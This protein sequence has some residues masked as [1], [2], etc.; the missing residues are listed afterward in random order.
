MLKV[1]LVFIY[2]NDLVRVPAPPT[3]LERDDVSDDTS[4]S[5]DE[6]G[7]VHR[8][9]LQPRS[10]KSSHVRME[11]TFQGVRV[12]FVL[13]ITWPANHG[14]LHLRLQRTRATWTF[15]TTTLSPQITTLSFAQRPM[16]GIGFLTSSVF[17][18]Y[19][20]DRLERATR[21]QLEWTRGSRLGSTLPLAHKVQHAHDPVATRKNS[22][23]S[24]SKCKTVA[25]KTLTDAAAVSI[26]HDHIPTRE[27]QDNKRR[28]HVVQTKRSTD[29]LKTIRTAVQKIESRYLSYDKSPAYLTKR[30]E[31]QIRRRASQFSR[32]R[33][34]QPYP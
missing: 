28:H 6:W 4:D 34:R 17:D 7:I 26:Q 13:V 29:R 25:S 2:L 23:S 31:N 15:S 11:T 27:L 18:A 10:F 32:E 16:F 9:D 30:M 12:S 14:P 20:S 1:E 22:E 24:E 19:V 5:D 3:S 21:R 8:P 33:P